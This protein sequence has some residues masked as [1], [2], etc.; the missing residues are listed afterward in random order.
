MSIGLPFFALAA[1]NPLMQ[2][3]FAETRHPD[4]RD[5]YFLYAASNIGSFLALLSYPILFEPVFTLRAQGRLWT[6][7]F[8]VLVVL[9]AGCGA[10]MLRNRHRIAASKKTAADTKPGWAVIGRWI[11]ISAVPSGLLVA[12]TAYVSTDIAAAPLLWVIPLS[13]YLLT[14]ICVQRLLAGS[15]QDHVAVATIRDRRDR[16]SALLRRLGAAARQFG[17]ASRGLFHHRNGLPW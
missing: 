16:S 14:W 11:F 15:A 7:A 3:W 9:V 4:A 10:L 1:N 2:A 12:V 17:G 13:L 5:P 6:I 8:T